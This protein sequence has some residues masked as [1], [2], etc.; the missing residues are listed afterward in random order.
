MAAHAGKLP[1]V[2][3]GAGCPLGAESAFGMCVEEG[4]AGVADRLQRG[5]LQ[6]AFFAAPRRLYFDVTDET[7]RHLR[8]RRGGHLV[9]LLQAAMTRLAC[10][11]SVQAPPDIRR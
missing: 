4:F 11:C 10:V 2:A 5:S 6:M 9:R 1:A 8:H 7:V 3:N